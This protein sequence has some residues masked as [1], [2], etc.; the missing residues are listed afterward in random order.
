MQ[1]NH[2]PCPF[3]PSSDAFCYNTNSG[4]FK[5]WSC[6]KTSGSEGGLIFD[7]ETLEPFTPKG[8]ELIEGETNLEPYIP[9]TYRGLSKETMEKFGVYFTLPKHIKS[10]GKMDHFYGADDYQSGQMITITE[11]EEDR[12]S[13]IQ[14]MGNW[15]C[16]SVPGATPSKDFWENARKY[17]S[18]FEKI[19]LSVDSD[20]PG[21]KLADK[22]YRMFPGKVYRVNHGKYKDAND[23][24]K[25]GDKQG[26]KNAWW[27]AH[28]VKPDYFVS[29]PDQWE[30]ILTEETPYQYTPTP[31]EALNKKVKGFVKG[32][33]TVI[34]ALPGTGKTSAFRYFQHYLLRNSDAKIAVLHMEEM[35]STTGRGL[36]TYDLGINV[37]TK[38]EA[39]WNC[40]EESTVIETIRDLTKDERFV[41]FAIDTSNP[42]EDTLE[43]IRVAREIYDVDFIFLDHLQRLA[44]LE[45]VENAT[46]GLTSL[47]VKIVD[48][49]RVD[50]FGVIAISHVNDDGATKYAKAVEE[51]AIVVIEMSRDRKADDPDERDT[52]YL[53]VT[54]NR[55]FGLTGSAGCLEYDH[56]TTIVKEKVKHEPQ[57]NFKTN[58]E[59][60]F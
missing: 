46:S 13:V 1:I 40:V 57:T 28:K 49:T 14:M 21:D 16:V 43:K 24:L 15:P 7:G 38:E 27:S 33:I 22:F 59:V 19:V 26:Y 6:N 48:M 56:D 3:C 58:G 52:T 39:S 29:S 2:Q 23:F 35:K 12:L 5:C 11:G 50:P 47:A 37:N 25:V 4:L 17:L 45:G 41:T 44:Y 55:P 36:V 54:K 60:S 32:G 20:E 53:D 10:S 34:K 31:V 8:I 42:I 9:D 30:K 51:E 18:N